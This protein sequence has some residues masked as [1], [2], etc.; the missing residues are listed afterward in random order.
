MNITQRLLLTF[1]LM[2]LA[3]ISLV[4]VT[5]SL[6][7]G[8]QSRFEYVQD[9]AIP[10][11][12][13]LNSLADKSNSLVL[14]LYRHQTTDDDRK[15]PAIEQDINRTIEEIK[16]L[17]EYYLINDASSEE[18]RQLTHTAIDLTKKLQASLPVFLN[19]SKANQNETALGLLQGA[20][21]PGEAVRELL[22]NY[23]K[24]FDLNVEMGDKLRQV[25]TRIYD[26]TWF[27]LLSGTLLIVL[28][29][30]LFAVRT[31]LGIR[32]SLNNMSQTME[33]VSTHL[34]LTIQAD[35]RRKDEVGNTARAFNSLMQRVSSALASVSASSQSVSSAATQIAAGNEDLSSRT[36]EQA[37]SLEQTAASMTEISETVRQNAENTQQASL[38]AGN[39]SKISINSA[40]SV[41]TMLNTMEHIRTS[42]GKI[43]EIIALI[44]GIAF[45]T[46]I[47]AL[48]AAVEAARAGE[49]GR[50][51]AVVAG[52][53][54]TLA[55]RSS[56]A[57]REIKD[58]IDASNSLVS[59]GVDQASD[60]GKN[61]SAMKDAIQQVT[62]LVNEIAAAT[63][64]QSQGISQVHQAV[65][66][67]DDV[68]QQ[69]AS[70]VEEASAASQSLQEQASTLSQLVGQFIVGQ[71][72]PMALASA[73]A[74][75]LPGVSAPR[76]SPVR[77]KGVIA[78]DE[79]DWQ[80]F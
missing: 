49:Q 76:L 27:G 46:N 9:N 63:E 54:R 7:S 44:E 25:N 38:L 21:G 48:N 60:V 42:S 62:D 52:E 35:E 24:Q 26:Q 20:G 4:I 50:G 28:L 65:N 16:K 75:A 31:I 47:L 45:Q 72:T 17:N 80:R 39:A 68:T 33:S 22:T 79:A 69:N 6:L 29:I 73:S 57:A 77:K 51:F 2:S 78:P 43:T 3:L 53:V 12:K 19:A 13:D 37:A 74:S 41:N 5:L 10:S 32:K 23:R 15:L 1:S 67:M 30:G 55:Q 14:F 70:L 66:Q 61:M 11:I 34:D 40:D 64:E 71:V 36:E 59:A 58:L 18:D 8:F 56:T